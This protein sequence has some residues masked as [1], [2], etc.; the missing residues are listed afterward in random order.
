MA[1]SNRFGRA[2]FRPDPRVDEVQIRRLRADIQLD[3]RANRSEL[4]RGWFANAMFERAGGVLGG[5]AEYKRYLGDLRRYQTLGRGT[6]ADVRLRLG[7]AKGSLPCQYLFDL[8]GLSTLRGYGF[9]QFTGDRMVLF[10]V[11]YWI[12]ADA[13]WH[14]GAMLMD[15]LSMG[16]FVDVGSA[17]FAA[18]AQNPHDRSDYL[19]SRPSLIERHMDLKK[20]FGFGLQ[21]G[22]SRLNIAKALDGV[23]RGWEFFA[24]FGRTF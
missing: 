21:L 8:G 3:M 23:G 20:S 15:D 18:D 1:F 16:I 13:Y 10:N 19:G 17:W 5:D 24:R 11:E 2:A 14:R 6:R 9:K 7:M 22:N 12:D 4:G